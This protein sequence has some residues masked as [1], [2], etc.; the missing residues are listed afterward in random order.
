MDM[1]AEA[2]V[3]RALA[4]IKM[5]ATEFYVLCRVYS[6]TLPPV[7]VK[8]LTVELQPPG[9]LVGPSGKTVSY[10]S[11]VTVVAKLI[12]RGY[13]TKQK[14]NGVLSLTGPGTERFLISYA[15]TTIPLPDSMKETPGMPDRDDVKL[16]HV[17]RTTRH[18]Y[19]LTL[20]ELRR[21]F[22]RITP[23]RLRS[24]MAEFGLQPMA[25]GNQSYKLS[26][27]D[28]DAE[29]QQDEGVENV[30]VDVTTMDDRSGVTLG[31]VASCKS[32]NR[33]RFR[34]PIKIARSALRSAM[35][36]QEPA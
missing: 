20:L 30:I 7:N 3:A 28:D 14:R 13:I 4:S 9:M 33:K 17:G 16:R 36:G 24:V 18:A 31:A 26:E 8:D 35:R 23:A 34:R 5:S 6:R 1:P 2:L 10:E 19:G 29:P 27:L 32:R 15:M 12:E 21:L 11:V 22:Q 25:W